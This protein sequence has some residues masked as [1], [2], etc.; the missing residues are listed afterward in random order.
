MFSTATPLALYSAI[1]FSASMACAQDKPAPPATAEPAQAPATQELKLPGVTID[2]EKKEV[3]V[4]AVACLETGILEFAVCKPG[5]FEH[6]A[7]F[8]TTAK[9][10]LIHAALLLCGLRASPQ[11]HSSPEIWWM[12]VEKKNQSR[13]QIHVEWE[14]E[15]KKKR[16]SL[17]E[18]MRSREA[19]G[20]PIPGQQKVE[21]KEPQD[22]WIFCGSFIHTPENGGNKLYA[23]NLSGVVVG[24]WPDPTALIQYGIPNENPYG[25]PGSGLEINE[26]TIPKTGTKVQ[27]IFTCKLPEAKEA[28]PAAGK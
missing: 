20:P 6:E 19:E 12:E 14:E 18:L 1:L 15:S 26:K 10:E 2:R 21:V 25:D 24:I 17:H 11:T 27:M 3:R 4:E 9:P 8:T 16:Y 28:A 7:L 5:T 13:V 23:A 22:S